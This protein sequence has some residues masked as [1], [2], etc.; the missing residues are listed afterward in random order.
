MLAGIP[1]CA[2]TSRKA[3]AFPMVLLEALSQSTFQCFDNTAHWH[4]MCSADIGIYRNGSYRNGHTYA[5]QRNLRVLSVS[6]NNNPRWFID[7]RKGWHT[8]D[9]G[10]GGWE[11]LF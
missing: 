10:K 5:L 2:A 3:L 11:T 4:S 9:D 7:N 8:V 6:Q 1:V